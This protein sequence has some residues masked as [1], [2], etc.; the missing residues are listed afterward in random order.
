MGGSAGPSAR[1]GQPIGRQPCHSPALRSDWL[2]ARWRN[3]RGGSPRAPALSRLREDSEAALG[4]WLGRQ[5]RL[6]RMGAG[7]LGAP[8]ERQGR[9]AAT[10][11]AA[12][13]STSADAEARRRE[14]LRRRASSA[15]PPGS[16]AAEGVRRER[17]GSLSGTASAARPRGEGLRKRRPRKCPG[18]PSLLRASGARAWGPRHVPSPHLLGRS[19]PEKAPPLPDPLA[20]QSRSQTKPFIGRFRAH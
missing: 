13:E 3:G 15:A 9:D 12:G 18:W 20:P 6:L 14:P 11:A 10:S 17:P 19:F 1:V 5:Q 16:G 4:G 2:A 7:R 8:M